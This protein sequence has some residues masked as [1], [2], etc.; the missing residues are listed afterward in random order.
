MRRDRTCILLFLLITLSAI[1][2]QKWTHIEYGA[3][4]YEPKFHSGSPDAIYGLLYSTLTNLVTTRGPK[5]V[6]YINDLEKDAADRAALALYDYIEAINR[7]RSK[8][9]LSPIE[10]QI[11]L[12]YGDFTL[13]GF[14]V[15]VT[16]T[17]HLKNPGQD[18]FQRGQIETTLQRLA[19]HSREGLELMTHFGEQVGVLGKKLPLQVL[20]EAPPYVFA[21]GTIYRRENRRYSISK[22]EPLGEVGEVG[23]VGRL[24]E[25]SKGFIHRCR[26]VLRLFGF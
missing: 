14:K 20:G 11:R 5:G 9:G 24:Y 3:G 7:K 23:E 17:A 8:D 19:N 6:F 16:D 26:E 18:L 1:S 10:I 21:D 12:L 4:N 25:P 2:E 22:K 15:P 13:P